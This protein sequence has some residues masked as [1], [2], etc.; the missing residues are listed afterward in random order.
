MD[1]QA[2]NSLPDLTEFD[3]PPPPDL[4]PEVLSALDSG[5]RGTDWTQAHECITM[6]RRIIKTQPNLIPDI[7]GSYGNVFDGLFA[8]GKTQVVKNLIRMAK[9][10]FGNGKTTN[11]ETAVTIFLP[12]LL[13]KAAVE[14]GHIKEIAQQT[15]TTFADCCGYDTSF[16]SKCCCT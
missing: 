4:T 10:I 5:V 12:L 2:S 1:P 9:E 14:F 13:K 15:L 11:V 16:A 8:S 6:F 7:I 3:L